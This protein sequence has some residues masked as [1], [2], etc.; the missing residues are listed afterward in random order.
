MPSK[1]IEGQV[2]HLYQHDAESFIWVL[3]W[4]CICYEDG[5]YIGKRTKLNDWL[6][7]D[8]LGCQKGKSSFL[9]SGRK[10]ITPSSSHGGIWKVARFCFLTIYQHYGPDV[11]P[12]VE[13]QVVF[14]TW[15]RKNILRGKYIIT[16][17]PRCSLVESVPSGPHRYVLLCMKNAE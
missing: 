2:K 15:L 6:R 5:A 12:T 7:V 8:A 17:A 10:T 14:E 1:A 3:T 4:A 16:G 11:V 9:F 13:D